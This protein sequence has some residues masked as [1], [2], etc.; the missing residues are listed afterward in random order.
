MTELSA[1]QSLE[2]G[3]AERNKQVAELI[4]D[5][6]QGLEV[7]TS[8]DD[9]NDLIGGSDRKDLLLLNPVEQMQ[10]EWPYHPRRI[11]NF[12]PHISA[13]GVRIVK[14][15]EMCPGSE[16][17]EKVILGR[18]E[19]TK[20]E[21]ELVRFLGARGDWSQYDTFLCKHGLSREDDFIWDTLNNTHIKKHAFMRLWTALPD[22]TA[23]LM[24]NCLKRDS[25]RPAAPSEEIFIA[26]TIMSHLVDANDTYVERKDGS[27]NRFLCR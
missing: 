25:T 6:R 23:K 9:L 4:E 24:S 1:L 19:Y 5:F 17:I 8:Q 7:V 2:S 3:V 26:Y 14:E 18:R 21:L 22:L 11:N 10:I 27:D 15:R 12:T 20:D 16:E 13:F